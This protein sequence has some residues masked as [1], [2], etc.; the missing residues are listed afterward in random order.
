MFALSSLTLY[1]TVNS[2]CYHCAV[3]YGFLQYGRDGKTLRVDR[4]D[5]IVSGYSTFTALA[6]E[7]SARQM[8]TQD[9]DAYTE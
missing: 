3:V 8:H 9:D 5:E 2:I 4:V 6:D 7:V 1:E